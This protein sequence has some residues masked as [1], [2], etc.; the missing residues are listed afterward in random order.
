MQTLRHAGLGQSQAKTYLTLLQH[1]PLGALQLA[2]LTGESRTNTYMLCDKLIRF[3][4]VMKME[5]KKTLYEA[6]HPSALETLA[7]KRRK[8]V[9]KSEKIVHDTVSELIATYYRT[10]DTPGVVTR[11]G[12]EGIAAVYNEIIE[13]GTDQ[14]YLQ[15]PH[16]GAYMG[17]DFYKEFGA[18]KRKRGIQSR[19][20]SVAD[21]K[22][23]AAHTQERELL[24]G[25]TERI[26]L[27]PGTYTAPVEWIVQGGTVSAITF[28]E[29]P[30]TLTIH[31]P[32]IADSIRQLFELVRKN[33]TTP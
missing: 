1:G 30:I 20:I 10:R 12:H 3:G 8:Q 14:Q 25:V 19:V 4:L 31:S 16:D 29:Q 33:Q 23:R 15:S 24:E 22:T 6:A 2:K 9:Q 17:E 28:T 21:T 11:F 27:Q 7:E 18:K 5:G 13:C 26:W 32:Q